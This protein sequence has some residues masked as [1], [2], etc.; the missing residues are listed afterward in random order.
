MDDEV[1]GRV[2]EPI[3][4]TLNNTLNDDASEEQKKKQFLKTR[5]ELI[6]YFSTEFSTTTK[7]WDTN[8]INRQIQSQPYFE[9]L[10]KAWIDPHWL[11]PDKYENINF[12]QQDY[13]AWKNHRPAWNY[14][15]NTIRPNIR[16][17]ITKIF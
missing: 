2:W 14:A 11:F 17:E 1:V 13:E 15:N 7:D 12:E 16:E 4:A 9:Q 8:K 3:L 10:Q 5:A 6:S